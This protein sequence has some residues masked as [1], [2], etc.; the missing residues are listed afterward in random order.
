MFPE[1]SAGLCETC[2]ADNHCAAAQRCATHL[3]GTTPI[4]PFC[5]PVATG[6]ASNTCNLTPYSGLTASTTVDG[7]SANLCLLRRTTCTGLG[8]FNVQ[9]CDAAADCGEEGLDDGR[10]DEEA[11]VCSIPCTNNIDCFDPGANSC[12]GGLCQL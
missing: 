2:V 12:L 11:E 4:G 9:V 1:G 3:F 6:A 7:V 5:F 8:D 10:C